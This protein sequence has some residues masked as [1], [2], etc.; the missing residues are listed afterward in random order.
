MLLLDPISPNS[1]REN[2]VHERIR[3]SDPRI[4]TTSALAAAQWAFVV[5]T[6]PSP[7]AEAFRC[8]PS[9]LYTF[10]RFPWSLARDWH[11][12]IS[13]KRSPTLSRSIALFPDATPN[14]IG[15]LCSILL[16]YVDT[17]L[18]FRREAEN[19]NPSRREKERNGH[20]SG[21]LKFRRRCMD[22]IASDPKSAGGASRRRV[23]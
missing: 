6:V 5:W 20:D 11:A 18:S 10:T 21:S 4:H 1:P 19:R 15:I 22:G 3:T 8:C 2:G 14:F 17:R 9:S 13:A 23:E 12:E 7:W 16:S